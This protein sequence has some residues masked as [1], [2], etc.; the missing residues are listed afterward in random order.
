MKFTFSMLVLASVLFSA[1]A[2]E[3][4]TITITKGDKITIA[5]SKLEGP[6]SAADAKTLQNDLAMSGYFT[7]S[8]ADRAQYLVGGSTGGGS[9]AGKVTDRAGKTTL[10]KNYTGA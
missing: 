1:G 4:P 2:Q 10:S 8:P 5:V 9:L 7:V 6:E 3:T